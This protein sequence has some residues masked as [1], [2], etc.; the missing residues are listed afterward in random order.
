MTAPCLRTLAGN[1]CPHSRTQHSQLH[2]RSSP[3][4]PNPLLCLDLALDQSC[5]KADLTPH[6]PH[7]ACDPSIQDMKPFCLSY[8]SWKSFMKIEVDSSALAG[9]TAKGWAHAVVRHGRDT[10]SGYTCGGYARWRRAL[11]K[12][13]RI[14]DVGADGP[15][16][17]RRSK[18]I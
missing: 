11:L 5:D 9:G 1:I 8:A 4:H 15:S 10:H 18:P 17:T 7:E 16:C 13:A 3:A 6:A 14:T 2:L 12:P